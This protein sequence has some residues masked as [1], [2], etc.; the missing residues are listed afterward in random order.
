MTPPEDNRPEEN[1]GGNQNLPPSK[2]QLG[3]VDPTGGKNSTGTALTA[4]GVPEGPTPAGISRPRILTM[5][6]GLTDVLKA[7]KRRWLLATTLAVTFAIPPAIAAWFFVPVTYTSQAWLQTGASSRIFKIKN[8]EA[9]DWESHEELI[10][11]Y[12]VCTAALD[13]LATSTLPWIKEVE[14]ARADPV[15]WLSKQLTVTIPSSKRE[16]EG[17]GNQL[18]RISMTGDDPVQLQ[19]LVEAV[20]NAYLDRVVDEEKKGFLKQRDVLEKSY[21]RKAEELRTRREDL[22]QIARDIGTADAK[23][24]SAQQQLLLDHVLY[25]RRQVGALRQEY[26]QKERDLRVYDEQVGW[27]AST[28]NILPED[29]EAELKD[30]PDLLQY[31]D[32]ILELRK[33]LETLQNIYRDKKAAPI[34]QMQEEIARMQAEQAAFEKQLR[35]SILTAL[36]TGEKKSEV[37]QTHERLA[38]EY[39]EAKQ[40]YENTRSE[41]S[42]LSDDLQQLGEYSADLVRRQEEL[43]QMSKVT[44]EVGYELEKIELELSAGGAERVR[45]YQQARVPKTGN[46]DQRDRITVMGGAAGLVLGFLIIAVPEFYKRRV[47]SGNDMSDG[48][49]VR[50]L[51]S[52]PMLVQPKRRFAVW[53][54]ANDPIEQLQATMD[55]SADGIRA[56]LL[57]IPAAESVRTLLVSS[58][59]PNEG[60]TTVAVS[61]AAS[62]GRSGRRTLLIDGDMRN[63]SAHRL[64]EMPLEDGLAEVLRGEVASENVIRPSQM[65][66]LRFMSAG[67]CDH[68]CLQALTKENLGEIFQKLQEEFDF[69]IVDSGPVLSVVDPLLLGQQCDAALLSVIRNVSRLMPAYETVERLQSTNIPVIGCVINGLESSAFISGYYTYGYGYGHAPALTGSSPGESPS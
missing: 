52:V 53:K 1:Q 47:T 21:D 43:A 69:I 66:G 39:R 51:G 30:H 31:A 59:L 20:T 37:Q 27:L 54:H 25:L 2:G 46:T 57:H 49:G 44:S 33:E 10:R 56:M 41:F 16:K 11:S 5:P 64:L 9:S 8:L 28:G 13:S 48:L 23:T 65:A 3:P 19:K 34:S 36:R 61:L 40:H 45:L 6:P 14:A 38:M 12:M 60:K 35:S 55:E 17:Y 67:H 29:M 18:L 63:P 15:D 62:M 22:Q 26:I 68:M 42:K 7:A 24:A 4:V 32:R 50:V 58:S